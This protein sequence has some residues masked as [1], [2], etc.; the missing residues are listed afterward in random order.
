MADVIKFTL[1]LM[2]GMTGIA[3]GGTLIKYAAQDAWK[4]KEKFS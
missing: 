2:L 4:L 3:A 1:K